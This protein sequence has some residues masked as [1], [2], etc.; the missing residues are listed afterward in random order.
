MAVRQFL[1]ASAGG[2]FREAKSRARGPAKAGCL[3][4]KARRVDGVGC[5]GFGRRGSCG[6]HDS[7]G[8]G[9]DRAGLCGAS[10]RAFHDAGRRSCA[11]AGRAPRA[12]WAT[13]RRPVQ[14][15]GSDSLLAPRRWTGGARADAARVPDQRSDACAGHSDHPQS[16]RD[17]DRGPRDSAISAH[18]PARR[19]A[20]RVQTG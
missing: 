13:L 1:H 10:V 19:D 5:R 3:Q 11:L 12:R 15:L 6:Q 9:A 7:A 20:Q 4:P 8:R 14:G 16:R 2:A 17:C 18:R